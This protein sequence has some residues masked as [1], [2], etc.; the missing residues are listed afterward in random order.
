MI[1]GITI[2]LWS[3]KYSS[4]KGIS[5]G[6]LSSWEC[7]AKEIFADAVHRKNQDGQF[8]NRGDYVCDPIGLG[9]NR[10]RTHCE[11]W[12]RLSW[13][14]DSV[15]VEAAV[16]SRHWLARF[17]WSAKEPRWKKHVAYNDNEVIQQVFE[18]RREE[19]ACVVVEPIAGN[20]GCIPASNSFLKL[21]RSLTTKY[22]ALLIFDEVMT[23]FRV[24]TS[25]LKAIQHT[26]RSNSSWKNYRWWSPGRCFMENIWCKRSLM[27]R[28]RWYSL[29]TL[30][31]D[32][33]LSNLEL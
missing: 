32:R 19:I 23:G 16:V 21:L 4:S 3:R 2:H 22:K 10:K 6:L 15:L 9:G 7:L 5:F 13:T 20:M 31:H 14:L 28:Y 26:T 27:A 33:W 8:R 30:C 1:A 18:E 24:G 17:P 11:I 12:W 29:E 25:G